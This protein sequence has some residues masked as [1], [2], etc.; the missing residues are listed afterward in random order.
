MQCKKL[1]KD[2]KNNPNSQQQLTIICLK[3]VEKHIFTHQ[4]HHF[5]PNIVPF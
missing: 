2:K 5:C 3:H 4:K 1:R